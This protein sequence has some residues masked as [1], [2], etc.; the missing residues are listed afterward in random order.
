MI[1]VRVVQLGGEDISV[2]LLKVMNFK[3]MLPGTV[4]NLFLTLQRGG[5]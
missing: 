3:F 1:T 4:I 2:L 5:F